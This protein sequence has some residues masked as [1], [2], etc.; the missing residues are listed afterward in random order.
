MFYFDVV[1]LR[2]YFSFVSIDHYIS[3]HFFTCFNLHLFF[4]QGKQSSNDSILSFMYCIVL[5]IMLFS[6]CI[7]K[8]EDADLVSKTYK[9]MGHQDHR[10]WKQNVHLFFY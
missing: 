4:L 10:L 8:N 5:S 6:P 1:N 2:Y 7:K 9:P 3:N